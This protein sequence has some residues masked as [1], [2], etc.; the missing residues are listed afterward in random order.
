MSYDNWH[1]CDIIMD[2][3]HIRHAQPIFHTLAIGSFIRLAVKLG[4]P[5]VG[6]FLFVLDACP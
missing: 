1:S 2:L 6:L 4:S 5:N 3:K